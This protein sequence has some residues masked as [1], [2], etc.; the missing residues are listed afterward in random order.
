MT[1]HLKRN[2]SEGPNINPIRERPLP[3]CGLPLPLGTLGAV[4]AA[5]ARLVASA[6]AIAVPHANRAGCSDSPPLAGTGATV[7]GPLVVPTRYVTPPAWASEQDVVDMPEGKFYGVRLLT[8][9][10][11]GSLAASTASSPS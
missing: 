11:R 1:Q 6:A 10:Y 7:D 2:D 5:D 9:G 3:P 8:F 4:C